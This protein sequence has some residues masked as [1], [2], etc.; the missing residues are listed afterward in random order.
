MNWAHFT[1]VLL[2]PTSFKKQ[3]GVNKGFMPWLLHSFAF[4][5][6]DSLMPQNYSRILS[7]TLSGVKCSAISLSR[8]TYIMYYSDCSEGFINE[9]KCCSQTI[10]ALDPSFA[11]YCGTW[12]NDIILQFVFFLSISGN[13]NCIF[14]V[15][16][17][18]LLNKTMPVKC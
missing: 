7:N 10:L 6:F 11:I 9:L 3:V 14:H 1:N 13:N 12:T 4:C 5:A 15:G 18:W 2:V 16:F 17:I 8:T